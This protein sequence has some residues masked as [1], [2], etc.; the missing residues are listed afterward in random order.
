MEKRD[1]EGENRNPK[2]QNQRFTID[3][4]MRNHPGSSVL[5]TPVEYRGERELPS[6]QDLRAVLERQNPGGPGRRLARS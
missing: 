2:L 3:P 6:R 4:R 5:A 1:E